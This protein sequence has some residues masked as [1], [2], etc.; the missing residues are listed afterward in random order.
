MI[1]STSLL[2][3]ASLLLLVTLLLIDV[4]GFFDNV[5]SCCLYCSDVPAPADIKTI[6]CIS[7][8]Y[9]SLPCYCWLPWFCWRRLFYIFATFVGNL[10]LLL[11]PTL[12][13]VFLPLLGSLMLLEFLLLL[14]CLL[15]LILLHVSR[16]LMAPCYVADWSA[17][18]GV[19]NIG[20]YCSCSLLLLTCQLQQVPLC[21]WRHGSCCY[22][23]SY[24]HPWCWH[25]WTL[26]A[27]LL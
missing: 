23:R 20:A 19:L 7:S 27:T 16:Q 21:C 5:V 15:W 13:L 12:L 24:F 10:S 14:P 18:A 8:I 3:M 17:V 26:Q 25:L 4:P 9:Y 11:A 1:L 6:V 2:L 22:H